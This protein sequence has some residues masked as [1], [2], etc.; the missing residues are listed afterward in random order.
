[1]GAEFSCRRSHILSTTW[2]VKILVFNILNGTV[3]VDED[4][5]EDLSSVMEENQQV[6]EDRYPSDSFLGIFWRQQRR[7]ASL[8]NSKSMKWEA[9]M[10]R[11]VLNFS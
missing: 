8:K 4:L 7:A 6:I 3:Q 11:L 2:N 10:I 1:M 9:A 5:H